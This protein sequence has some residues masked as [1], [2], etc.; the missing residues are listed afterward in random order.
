LTPGSGYDKRVGHDLLPDRAAGGAK[1]RELVV[2]RCK[3]SLYTIRSNLA[4]QARNGV[5]EEERAG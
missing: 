5:F 4:I 3:C 1:A 2:P